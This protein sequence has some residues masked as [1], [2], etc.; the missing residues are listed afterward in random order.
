MAK[1]PADILQRIETLLQAGRQQEARLLLLEYLKTDPNSARAWW[2]LSQ[3]VIDP[4]QKIDCLERVLKLDPENIEA[5]QRLPALK[6]ATSRPGVSASPAFVDESELPEPELSY[7]IKRVNLTRSEDPNST[8]PF[9]AEREFVPAV[10]F[11]SGRASAS[12]E[13]S[14]RKWWVLEGLFTLFLL[15]LIGLTSLYFWNQQKAQVAEDEA[16]HLRETRA[17]ALF[18]TDLP[19]G[20][21]LPAE[22]PTYAATVDITQTPTPEILPTVGP[23]PADQIRPETGYFAPSFSLP[24]VKSNQR[25]GVSQFIGQPVLLYFCNTT[26]PACQEELDTVRALHQ[27]YA[28]RGLVILVIDSGEYTSTLKSYKKYKQLNNHILVDLDNSV[29]NQYQVKSIPAFY[30]IDSTGKIVS[31]QNGSVYY[32]QLEEELKTI[33]P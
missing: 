30:F 17:V 26:S 22:T 15:G 31:I 25:L 10:A 4:V 21:A 7:G 13:K 5:R 27:N 8:I 1:S 18:L 20:T 19:T 14:Q 9:A 33:L 16:N 29:K 24:D 3:A 6:A 2:I 12:L 11:S 32:P 23:P 28:K